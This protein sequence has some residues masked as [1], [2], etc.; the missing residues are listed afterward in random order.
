MIEI[1]AMA[2]KKGEIQPGT[3]SPHASMAWGRLAAATGLNSTKLH[4]QGY[5]EVE[6]VALTPEEAAKLLPK[7]EEKKAEVGTEGTNGTNKT[8]GTPAE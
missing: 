6:L 2:N 1:Y 3:V 4:K 7:V 8:E 5:A